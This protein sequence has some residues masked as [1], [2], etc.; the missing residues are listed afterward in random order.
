MQKRKRATRRARGTNEHTKVQAV[1]TL[2]DDDTIALVASHGPAWLPIVAEL[3]LS[4]C[5]RIGELCGTK[6]KYKTKAGAQSTDRDGLT[7]ADVTHMDTGKVRR[8][9]PEQPRPSVS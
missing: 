5:M 2:P 1:R 7:L 6:L 8:S 9:M 3:L 4:T